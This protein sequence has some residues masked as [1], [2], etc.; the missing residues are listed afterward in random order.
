[1]NYL[2]LEIEVT[3]DDQKAYPRPWTAV[4]IRQQLL[5][6]DEL[7]EFVCQENEKS[8]RRFVN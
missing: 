1:V 3:V 8:T 5:A 4:K 6:D 2:N 7:I